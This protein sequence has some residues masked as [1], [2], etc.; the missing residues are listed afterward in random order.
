MST[1]ATLRISGCISRHHQAM[2]AEAPARGGDARR[3][4]EAPQAPHHRIRTT[5]HQH[6]EL[7]D[8]DR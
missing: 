6:K 4:G 7:S 8:A 5:N 3:D 1:T 2:G